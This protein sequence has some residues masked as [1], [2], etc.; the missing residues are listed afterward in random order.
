VINQQD[1][2]FSIS[3]DG[4]EFSLRLRDAAVSVSRLATD[5]L[6]QLFLSLSAGRARD[7]LQNIYAHNSPIP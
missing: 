4:K 1:F 6:G 3:Q 5:N 7:L 2:M